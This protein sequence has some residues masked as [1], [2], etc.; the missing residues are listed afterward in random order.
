VRA[1]SDADPIDGEHRVSGRDLVIDVRVDLGPI[2]PV[3]VQVA[4]GCAMNS[5]MDRWNHPVLRRRKAQ[6]AVDGVA[7]ELTGC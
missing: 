3:P 4:V 7:A 2:R 6:F 5:Q 1:L